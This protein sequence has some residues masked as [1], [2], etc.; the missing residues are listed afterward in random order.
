MCA[1]LFFRW[2]HQTN[3][4][5]HWCIDLVNCTFLGAY[6]LSIIYDVRGHLLAGY[7]W[8]L[9]IAFQRCHSI[10]CMS[11]IPLDGKSVFVASYYDIVG[12]WSHHFSHTL[13]VVIFHIGNNFCWQFVSK[14]KYFPSDHS[15]W[16]II[17][18]LI[19]MPRACHVRM[20]NYR[21]IWT[22]FDDSHISN[23]FE[24]KT[25]IERMVNNI[26]S[27]RFRAYDAEFRVQCTCHAYA[28]SRM[29]KHTSLTVTH[30]LS[31][32]VL[33]LNA[34]SA[35]QL[36]GSLLPI[37]SKVVTLDTL[38]QWTG[39]RAVARYKLCI[40]RYN[41][42]IVTVICVNSVLAIHYAMI[43]TITW[44]VCGSRQPTRQVLFLH[45]STFALCAM[46]YYS[47]VY[48]HSITMNTEYVFILCSMI[49]HLVVTTG[50]SQSVPHSS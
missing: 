21:A 34:F 35:N 37:G 47:T 6:W 48:V 27:N 10:D 26:L 12:G 2:G 33:S 19:N 4:R 31:M 1:I 22:R 18:L 50:I 32:N 8:I 14:Y 46:L 42:M 30:V 5:T 40:I 13:P 7:V 9:G 11:S 17:Y 44:I 28:T 29:C 24:K 38:Q 20:S 36:T 49:A 16:T 25:S 41:N 3:V 15:S 43:I 39:W 23:T 45:V